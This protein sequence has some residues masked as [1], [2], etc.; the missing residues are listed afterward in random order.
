MNI[1]QG[2]TVWVAV[3]FL[4]VLSTAVTV[5]ASGS[6]MAALLLWSKN[7]RRISN[8]KKRQK[9][10]DNR[11]LSHREVQKQESHRSWPFGNKEKVDEIDRL[12]NE[13]LIQK[14]PFLLPK[15]SLGALSRDIDIPVHY[16]S[17][18]INFHYKMRFTDFINSHRVRHSKQMIIDGECKRKKLAAI[19]FESGFNN[20]NTF[21][22]AFKKETGQS[23]SEFLKIISEG[24]H[25]G[26]KLLK[27]KKIQ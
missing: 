26:R 16:L 12:L 20:R 22:T 19:S 11:F 8:H 25:D 5:M 6:A 7:I 2:A 10:D 27:E 13:F 24:N 3:I 1:A 4:F 23:P 9:G 14:E 21:T 17:A 15:Y 18:F